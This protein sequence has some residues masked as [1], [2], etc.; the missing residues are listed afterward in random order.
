MDAARQNRRNDTKFTL[1]HNEVGLEIKRTRSLPHVEDADEC[2]AVGCARV[3]P[4]TYC[5][6]PLRQTTDRDSVNWRVEP[7]RTRRAH[8]SDPGFSAALN[9]GFRL[10]L[11][12]IR[13]L[14]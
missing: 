7:L 11:P 8:G 3:S 6:H 2:S 4:G 5:A 1:K 14:Q 12:V 9:R 13:C 10:V